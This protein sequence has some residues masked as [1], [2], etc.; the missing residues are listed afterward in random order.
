MIL[1]IKVR[2]GL[3]P[4]SKTTL[5]PSYVLTGIDNIIRRTSN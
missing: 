1:N 2:F 5:I 3:Q 4:T